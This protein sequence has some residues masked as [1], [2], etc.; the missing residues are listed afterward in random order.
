MC[1]FPSKELAA[2]VPLSIIQGGTLDGTLLITK[3][4]GFG[5]TELLV[6][7]LNTLS[8]REKR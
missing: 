4:G 8:I 6:T 1:F 2:G 3:S 7:L 5:D